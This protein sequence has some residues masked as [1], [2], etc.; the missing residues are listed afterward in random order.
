MQKIPNPWRG[1]IVCQTEL[2]GSKL[3]QTG[4][5]VKKNSKST[6][7]RMIVAPEIYIADDLQYAKLAHLSDFAKQSNRI[8]WW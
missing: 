5:S 1:R 7:M 3:V 2:L 8:A 6:K 4:A